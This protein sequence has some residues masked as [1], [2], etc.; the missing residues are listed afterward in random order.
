MKPIIGSALK[1]CDKVQRSVHK[2][3]RPDLQ[4]DEPTFSSRDILWAFIT[5]VCLI[6]LVV[7][8]GIAYS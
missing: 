8:T 1:D 7:I 6:T 3:P 2:D 5:L 4:F